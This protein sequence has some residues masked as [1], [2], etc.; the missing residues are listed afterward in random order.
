MFQLTLDKIFH[1]VINYKSKDYIING[2]KNKQKNKRQ[3]EAKI[4]RNLNMI[5]T[6]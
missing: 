1:S 2:K 3:E 4:G 5:W 6:K